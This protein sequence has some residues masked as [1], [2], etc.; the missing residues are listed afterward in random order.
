VRKCLREIV[1]LPSSSANGNAEHILSRKT[2]L[3]ASI[4]ISRAIAGVETYLHSNV[5]ESMCMV[6]NDRH[7]VESPIPW[8]GNSLLV[9]HQA[10]G[11]LQSQLVRD[12]AKRP[13]YWCIDLGLAACN[14]HTDT[15]VSDHQQ[16]SCFTAPAALGSERTPCTKMLQQR[17]SGKIFL[18]T[19]P[20]HSLGKGEGRA[21]IPRLCIEPAQ[22]VQ[23]RISVS[24]AHSLK[25]ESYSD[26]VNVA[27]RL[28]ALNSRSSPE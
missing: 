17:Y 1:L 4:F 3:Q 14:S 26:F 13:S 25:K 15:S 21:R 5:H 2:R 9:V 18:S 24:T 20:N 27:Q 12:T 8:F 6:Q 10:T 11:E 16:Y 19:L 23:S 28:M 22:P 7:A